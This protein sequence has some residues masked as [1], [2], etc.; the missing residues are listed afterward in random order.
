MFSIYFLV[1]NPHLGAAENARIAIRQTLASCRVS[2]H[3]RMLEVSRHRI[4]LS[5]T[6]NES[7]I[8]AKSDLKRDAI[9]RTILKF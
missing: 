4:G 8:I 9:L 5:D 6:E 3:T 7:M 1:T 2:N